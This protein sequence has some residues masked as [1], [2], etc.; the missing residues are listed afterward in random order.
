MTHLNIRDYDN[1]NPL[2]LPPSIDDFLPEGDLSR[3]IDEIV[4]NHIGLSSLYNKI[5]SRG[6]PAYHP[7]MMVKVLFY[8]Y[9]TGVRESR[10]IQK[11]LWTDVPFIFLAGMQ[12]PDFRT[13]SDFRKNNLEEITEIFSQIVQVCHKLGMVKIGSVSLDSK[14]F[15]A[16]AG[17]GRI[18]TEERILKEEEKINEQIKKYFEE[19]AELD[20]LDDARYGP[21]K[22]GDELPEDIATREKRKK[23]LEEIQARLDR[24]KK[25]LQEQQAE[26]VKKVNLT[27]SD[28]RI[29]RDKGQKYSG[30]R[31]QIVVDSEEQVIIAQDINNAQSDTHQL[32]P[33]VDKTIEVVKNLKKDQEP[34]T[35]EKEDEK[36]KF[37]TDSGY[38]ALN[39]LA[40]IEDKEGIDP[41]IPDQDSQARKQ[42]HQN[43]EDSP[44]SKS[45]FI[46]QPEK[47]CFV[48]PA[49]REL[50]Y[51]TSKKSRTG[52]NTKVYKCSDC[53]SCPHFGSCTKNK[54]GRTLHIY[55][56]DPLL[57]KMRLKLSSKEG[58]KNYALR[59]TTVEPVYGNLAHNLGY[60]EFL[61]RGTPKVRGEFSLFCI[62]HDLRKIAMYIKR[63]G[64]RLSERLSGLAPAPC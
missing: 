64:L 22:R 4:E 21:D 51:F 45:K 47:D 44:F 38:Y 12:K 6:N 29:Q 53:Q 55:E 1:Q 3:V 27:D 19:S 63:E 46:F 40:E 20:E 13:I 52:V 34:S 49:G 43:S 41:H 16:N 2:L 32:I 60:R 15:K 23:K 5:S 37:L 9:A 11:K 30:Y 48:C 42:G 33:M 8:G 10:R 35:S 14:V 25:L 36:I 7:R 26:G 62:A 39:N 56:H 28:S 24:A 58:R 54:S 31:S 57:K 50:K 18:Y 59:K 61:L 17:R